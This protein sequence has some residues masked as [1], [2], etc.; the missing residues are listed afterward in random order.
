MQYVNMYQYVVY[1]YMCVCFS[2]K[3]VLS[4]R[5]HVCIYAYACII[6]MYNA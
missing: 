3:T 2:Q 1:S 5:R 4:T 6:Y